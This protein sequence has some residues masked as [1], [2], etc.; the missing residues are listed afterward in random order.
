MRITG[1]FV[2]M[3]NKFLS[4]VSTNT[5]NAQLKYLLLT[6][7]NFAQTKVVR[8]GGIPKERHL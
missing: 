2:S 5:I 7:I 4:T 8:Y 1:K 3:S 6:I